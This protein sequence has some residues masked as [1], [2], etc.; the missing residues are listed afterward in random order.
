MRPLLALP[1][2]AALASCAGP[3]LHDDED[4][5]VDALRL[6]IVDGDHQVARAGAEVQVAPVVR[7][8]DPDGGAVDG[9]EVVFV[10]SDPTGALGVTTAMTDADGRASPGSWRLGDTPGT[11][12]LRV[13]ADLADDV[14]I[15]ATAI[16]AEEPALRAE[17]W[18]VDIGRPWD[19][20][21]LPDGT[22]LITER[23]GRVR[24]VDPGARTSRVILEPPA[25]LQAVG[26]SGMLGIAVDPG[27]ASNRRVYTYL[28]SNRGGATDNRIRRWTLD[29]GA[30]ALTEDRDI[31]TGITF[32]SGGAHSGG[33]IRFGPDGHLWVTTG[34]TLSATVPQDKG[35]LGGKVL[36][37]TR[38]GAP[39][40]GN[41]SLGAGARPEIY[42]VGVRN[43]QGIAF[44]PGVGDVFLCEHG[45]NT[46]DE[47][48]RLVA[49]G[50]GG[51]NPNDGNGTYT[52]YTGALMSDPSIPGLVEPT[53]TARSQGMSGCDFL[54]GEAW[55]RWD[56]S[57]LVGFLAG[58]RADVLP[59]DAP[60]TGLRAEIGVALQAG[61][62]LRSV[63]Q[64][65]DGAAYVAIDAGNGPIWRVTAE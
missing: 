61:A 59:V 47:V 7:L 10:D 64:G 44:R 3:T 49:G 32:G 8:V 30:T 41:P 24:A 33:R 62:R 42:F 6:V 9:Y 52:G 57:L 58:G 15:S 51:W 27:F 48:T 35:E 54:V 21:F 4:P 55:R 43:P 29:A 18:I 28:T 17:P 36:R 60:G 34:D 39:A 5:P 45:P 40:P 26:Q 12:A 14:T 16:A 31:L 1:V 2:V 13:G 37:V 25:D 56:R 22:M 11:K 20:A 63:V 53:Y 50:N 65:P 38:D 19:L 23:A 46:V